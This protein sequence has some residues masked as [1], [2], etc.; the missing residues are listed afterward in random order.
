MEQVLAV[1]EPKGPLLDRLATADAH[2]DIII[3]LAPR[4]FPILTR[5]WMKPSKCA[6][7]LGRPQAA[8]G[9]NRKLQS[10]RP[11]NSSGGCWM[12]KMPRHGAGKVEELLQQG[13]AWPAGAWP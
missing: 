1:T 12:A 6:R 11:V 8:A 3:A 4:L 5:W 2:Q 13:R 9:R 10:D 7:G